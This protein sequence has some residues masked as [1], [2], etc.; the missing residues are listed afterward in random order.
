MACSIKNICRTYD[1]MNSR[2]CHMSIPWHGISL[3]SEQ[4]HIGAFRCHSLQSSRLTTIS[5]PLHTQYTFVYRSWDT[6]HPSSI[7]ECTAVVALEWPTSVKQSRIAARECVL[8]YTRYCATR[9][10]TL[11][12]Y[13]H[14]TKMK[15]RM[16]IGGGQAGTG[17]RYRAG[18]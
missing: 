7:Q 5:N 1:S 14:L 18:V 2:T 9:A 6:T 8:D 11:T 10:A 12:V 17:V 3:P 16:A 4:A 13:G 15:A